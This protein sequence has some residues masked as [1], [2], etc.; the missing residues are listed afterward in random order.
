MTQVPGLVPPAFKFLCAAMLV[1][2]NMLPIAHAET[3]FP[4]FVLEYVVGNDSVTAGTASLSLSKYDDIWTYSL[5]TRPT[6][7]F[8]LLGRGTVDES[9]TFRY[10]DEKQMRLLNY[11]F[12]QDGD[13]RRSVDANF[14]CEKNIL[15]S[16]YRGVSEVHNI[17]CDVKD[18]LIVTL[19][20][21][22]LLK[23]GLSKTKLPVYGRGAINTYTFTVVGKEKLDTKFGMLETLKVLSEA[24]NNAK[25]RVTATWFAPALDYFP[26]L[27]EQH[28]NGELVARMQLSKMEK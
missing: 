9:S 18:R 1:L 2:S 21:I 8:K 12:R 7:F 15:V 25:N 28:K 20:I 19:D 5:R 4:S 13:S 14:N 24:D 16:I 11:T 23:N 3:E 22:R 27:I 26:V 17:D 6:G 10:T